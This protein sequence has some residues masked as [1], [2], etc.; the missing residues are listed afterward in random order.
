MKKMKTLKIKDT[1]YEVV[2]DAAR[3]DISELK[4]DIKNIHQSSSLVDF[5]NINWIE[6]TYI[7][8]NTGEEVS[9]AKWVAT[10]YIE[11]SPQKLACVHLNDD[12][13]F[14]GFLGLVYYAWYDSNKK[15]LTGA[16]QK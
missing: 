13:V 9:Y 1:S 12:G 6:D 2:D 5:E 8:N 10:D 7:D 11:L 4:S 3:T 15:Y 14:S 16:K